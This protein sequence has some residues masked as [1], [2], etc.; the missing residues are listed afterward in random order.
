MYTFDPVLLVV[1]L[2]AAWFDTL[3]E[4]LSSGAYGSYAADAYFQQQEQSSGSGSNA[5]ARLA[6]RAVLVDMEPKVWS[7][8]VQHLLH[9]SVN[10]GQ[11]R[12]KLTDMVSP[13]ALPPLAASSSCLVHVIM[14]LRV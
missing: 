13:G 10:P 7:A 1:Q 5:A 14:L 6:A 3:A 12:V 11:T 2:G 8:A 4:E 9:L